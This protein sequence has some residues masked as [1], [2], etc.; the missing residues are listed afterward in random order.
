MPH[1]CQV[2]RNLGLTLT[3][4]PHPSAVNLLLISCETLKMADESDV[5]LLLFT[6]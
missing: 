3:D 2:H 4:H 6:V 5:L 1:Y